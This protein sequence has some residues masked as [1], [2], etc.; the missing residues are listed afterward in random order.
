[1]KSGIDFFKILNFCIGRFIGIWK[2]VE[3]V[4]AQ[5]PFE[6]TWLKF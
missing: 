6:G 1:M 4:A 2:E 3:I 5:S